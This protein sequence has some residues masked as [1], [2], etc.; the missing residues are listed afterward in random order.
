MHSLTSHSEYQ[1]NTRN[2]KTYALK[3][4]NQFKKI[5]PKIMRKQMRKFTGGFIPKEQ[6]KERTPPGELMRNKWQ[7]DSDR[8]E[9][10]SDPRWH[11][12]HQANSRNQNQMPSRTQER[13]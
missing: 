2:Q 9:S 10:V 12:N 5:K 6:K 4:Q 1:S 3:R 8:E 11:K 7:G 13:T